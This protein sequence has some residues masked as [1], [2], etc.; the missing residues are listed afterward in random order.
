MKCKYY[1]YYNNFVQYICID[2][3]ECPIEYN[4]L[5]KEKN[6]LTDNCIKED[7]YK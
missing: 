3:L 6:K 1:Y 4:L 2:I 5:I 7:I